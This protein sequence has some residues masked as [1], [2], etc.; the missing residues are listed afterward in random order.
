MSFLQDFQRVMISVCQKLRL[1][2]LRKAKYLILAS[3]PAH[4]L[5]TFYQRVGVNLMTLLYLALNEDTFFKNE[6]FSKN[7][8]RHSFLNKIIID[9]IL[10]SVCKIIIYIIMPS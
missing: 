7:Y 5:K 3:I 8:F 4:F 2:Q 9:H 6:T 10:F 1:Q